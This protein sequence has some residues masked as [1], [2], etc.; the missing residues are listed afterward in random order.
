MSNNNPKYS[1]PLEALEACKTL[2]QL[3]QETGL[4]KPEVYTKFKLSDDLFDCPACE[5][6]RTADLSD[7]LA[8]DCE[9]CPLYTEGIAFACCDYPGPYADYIHAGNYRWDGISAAAT[10][11]LELIEAQIA[12]LQTKEQ[13]SQ[14]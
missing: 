11:M 7:C 13:E 10:G 1:S 5:Y 2:W 14:S 12:K 9:K 6:T 4:T 3:V 8:P